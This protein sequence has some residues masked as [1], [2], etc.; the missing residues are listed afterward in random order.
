MDFGRNE[1]MLVF[2]SNRRN[3]KNNNISI[4][5]AISM[6]SSLETLSEKT[7]SSVLSLKIESWNFFL[8]L[9]K[10]RLVLLFFIL[11]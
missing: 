4:D 11:L 2:L 5:A 7:D 6:P 10:Y 3:I 9:S 1:L 8:S